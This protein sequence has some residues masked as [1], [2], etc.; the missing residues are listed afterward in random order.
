[1]VSSSRPTA[2]KQILPS[3]SLVPAPAPA[4]QMQATV[5]PND[6]E[7][8][9]VEVFVPKLAL[10]DFTPQTNSN[11]LM[12]TISQAPAATKQKPVVNIDDLMKKTMVDVT[13]P[14]TNTK[15]LFPPSSSPFLAVKRTNI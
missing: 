2:T 11:L 12:T 9:F 1:M 14:T 10:L 5:L 15:V 4:P 6:P 7:F 8:S 13:K 3:G